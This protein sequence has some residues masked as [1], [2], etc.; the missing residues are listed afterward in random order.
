MDS[1]LLAM[2]SNTQLEDEFA[3]NHNGGQISSTPDVTHASAANQASSHASAVQ[4]WDWREISFPRQFLFDLFFIVGFLIVDGSSTAAK[5]WEGAPPWYLPVGL[6]IALLLDR[7]MLCMPLIFVSSV[8]AAVLNYHRP[9]FSWCGIPG[10]IGAYLG[11]VGTAIVLRGPWRADLRRGTVSDV[12]RYL[13]ACFAGSLISLVVGVF[14]LL[15][16]GM[17]GWHDIP[18]TAAEWWTTDTLA[19]VAF[20]PFLVIYVAPLLRQWVTAGTKVRRFTIWQG[21]SS[22]AQI[23]EISAQSGLV[24]LAVWFVFGYPPAV[25]Y[26]PL[27]LL[28]IPVVWVAVRRGLPGAVLTT[29]SVTVAMTIAAW[30]TQAQRGSQPRLQLAT[31]VL[32]LT[33]LFLGAVVTER[34][35]GEQSIRAS[36]TRYRLL[37]ERNL[38]GVFRT[39]ISG[40]FL[41]CNPAAAQLFGYESP[42][43]VL[44]LPALNL[45]DGA[46][47]R[48]A[49]LAKLKSEKFLTNYTL[50]L[51]RKNGD[52]VWAMLNVSLV[53][54]GHGEEEILEGTLVDI[55]ERKLA[56][57]RIESLAYYD[58]LTAL[59]NRLLLLD[60]LSQGLAAARRQD[61]KLALLFFDLDRFKNINDSLGHSIGDVL[62]QEVATRLKACTR[63]QD[64]VARLGGDEF[65]I[66]LNG[67]TDVSHV[68]VAAE[69][70]M[71]TML[72]EF[73]IQGHSLS[74]GCSI[75]I[76]IFPDHGADTETLI[77]HADAAM[78]CAKDRGRN[79]FQFFTPDMNQQAVERLTLENGLRVALEKEQFFL[80]YQPQLDLVSGKIIGLE[81]L[82]RWRHPEMGL[83]PPDRFIRIAENSGLILPVGEW[84]LRTACSQARDW[85]RDLLWEVPVAVNVSAVQFRHEHF[86][87]RVRTILEETGLA[88][89]RLELE[90]TESLLLA[91]ADITLSVLQRL[92]SMGLTLTIDDFGTG[93]SSLSYLKR[94]PVSKLK[95]DRSFIRDVA[96]NSDDAAITTAIISMAKSLN[97]GGSRR[98]SKTK[99]K[100][101]SCGRSAVMEFRD[102]LL[103]RHCPPRNSSIIYPE[104][105]RGAVPQR[106]DRNRPNW[107]SDRKNDREQFYFDSTDCRDGNP[108]SKHRPA[109]HLLTV[110][111]LFS[112]GFRRLIRIFFSQFRVLSYFLLDFHRANPADY[113]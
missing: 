55:T 64:T 86:C 70:F 61:Q 90:M 112:P 6:S 52:P 46:S 3:S 78:Y 92:K 83:I 57:E 31:L 56:E 48:E 110:L 44:S 1:S 93:Y 66:V 100:P 32:G 62:L 27:Y 40:Q 21:H 79:N 7:G 82:L 24:V 16:D 18:T 81:A 10:A 103:V 54:S 85:Q 50:K 76:S 39:T 105:W 8:M 71:D 2:T 13:V 25:P 58:T 36:E 77:K 12:G 80:A 63:E 49:L 89:R 88:P 38:A 30:I 69:R 74:V 19:I 108:V 14:T 60:R 111:Y 101:A 113:V 45:Y 26:Q 43:Q 109:A 42:Q 22:A 4:I 15:G 94:F 47:D 51:R 59:P 65:L 20:A 35:Q 23:L 91:N 106:N 28:F 29:F 68:A 87:E 67:V 9:I 37:F 17:I 5:A 34:Q 72:A 96:V 107:R 97:R 73:V 33:G 41:E 84:V 75:G 104:A 53:Q 11:Y 95:I 99:H 102:I 98:A